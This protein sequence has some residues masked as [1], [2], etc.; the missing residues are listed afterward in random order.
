[1][2]KSLRSTDNGSSFD[3]VTSP[4][5]QEISGESPSGTIPS[6]QLEKREGSL[7]LLTMDQLLVL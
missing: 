6:W 4:L 7:D 3:N 1:M 2:E 5:L